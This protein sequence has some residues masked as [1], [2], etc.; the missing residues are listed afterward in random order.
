MKRNQK[1]TNALL[2][3]LEKTFKNNDEKVDFQFIDNL[4]LKNSIDVNFCD[5]INE[6]AL[7]KVTE[8]SLPKNMN[9]F[10]I[11]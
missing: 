10:L 5:K 2:Y 8:Q 11:I 6:N 7:F 4:L 3:Y 1:N 9:S